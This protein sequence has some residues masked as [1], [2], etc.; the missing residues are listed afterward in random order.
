M[1]IVSMMM[2][3]LMVSGCAGGGMIGKYGDPQAIAEYN[4]E[5]R[6]QK[7][8]KTYRVHVNGEMHV[9][10]VRGSSVSIR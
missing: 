10:R 5:R 9:I 3:V 6:A 2:L 8:T 4:A 1:K 7:K